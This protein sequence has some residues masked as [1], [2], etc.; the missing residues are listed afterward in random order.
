MTDIFLKDAKVSLITIMPSE[1]DSTLRKPAIGIFT[2]LNETTIP[3]LDSDSESSSSILPAFVIY[4]IKPVSQKLNDTRVR[5]FFHAPNAMTS[6]VTQYSFV[7]EVHYVALSMSLGA[8]NEPA[9]GLPFYFINADKY[10][11]TPKATM[12]VEQFAFALIFPPKETDEGEEF[13]EKLSGLVS[14]DYAKP[15]A[16]V[17]WD[18]IQQENEANPLVRSAQSKLMMMLLGL[19]RGEVS[20]LME[21]ISMEEDIDIFAS[22]NEDDDID[23]A[24]MVRMEML[25]ICVQI[26]QNAY[27]RITNLNPEL[28]TAAKNVDNVSAVDYNPQ[29]DIAFAKIT[30]DPSVEGIFNEV[31]ISD[32]KTPGEIAREK[33]IAEWNK[34]FSDTWPEVLTPLAEYIDTLDHADVYRELVDI[35][36]SDKDLVDE[37]IDDYG[38]GKIFTSICI[39]IV[40]YSLKKGYLMRSNYDAT[41]PPAILLNDWTNIF[42]DDFVW[43]LPALTADLA[44]YNF[45]NAVDVFMMYYEPAHQVDKAVYLWEAVH[46]IGHHITSSSEWS[47]YTAEKFAEEFDALNINTQEF[48]DFKS[49]ILRYFRK[50]KEIQ[51]AYEQQQQDS[52][53]EGHESGCVVATAMSEFI[54]EE[55]DIEK[56]AETV[57]MTFPVLADLVALRKDLEPTSDAWAIVRASYIYSLLNGIAEGFGDRIRIALR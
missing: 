7:T 42:E 19:A 38:L 24:S 34:P 9:G 2:S 52:D 57:A 54:V 53:D 23:E 27:Q 15:L 33:N 48:A 18:E 44:S 49:W 20:P 10:K 25:S 1:P 22:D 56:M 47:G 45:K 11:P 26:A 13:M 4:D 39:S 35:D 31:K 17:A 5:L 46:D 21:L 28:Q 12:G 51:T 43:E 32:G 40:S 36:F 41:L 55:L 30:S 50:I 3:T 29:I 8:L 6:E 14:E 37:K 16:P